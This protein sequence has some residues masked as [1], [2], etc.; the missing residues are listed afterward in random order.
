MIKTI[1]PSEM[2]RVEACVMAE[3]GVSGAAL[4]ERAAARVA[5]QA[6]AML[7]GRAGY[8][9]CL[10]GTGNNGGDGLA[11]MRI[12]AA[13]DD[14]FTGECLLLEGKLSPDAQVQ[15]ERLEKEQPRIAVK[16]ISDE[17]PPIRNAALIIDALFGTGLSRP[18]EGAA[19]A[20][21]ARVREA[22]AAGAAVLAVDIPSGLNGETGA[23]LGD[24]VK[25]DATVVF[26][27]PKLGLYVGDGLDYTGEI[28]VA[29]I[30]LPAELD[31]ADGLSVLEK[32]DLA[33]LLPPRKRISHK[34][35]YG[36]VLLWVGSRGMAG[37]AAVAALAALRTGAGLV[38][39][40]CPDS[41]VDIV[42]MLC[43]CAMCAPLDMNDVDAAWQT[44]SAALNTA[45]AAGAGCGLG[46]TSAV[47]ELLERF[48]NELSNNGKPAVLDADALNLLA[49][50]EKG[51][52][53]KLRD[54]VTLTPHPAEAARLIG[55]KTEDITR[56]CIHAARLIAGEYGASIVLKGASSVLA[57]HD[58]MA[59][60]P[61]GSPGM[62]KGGSGDALTGVL[63]ALFAGC[64]AGAYQMTD[65]QTLQAACALHGLAGEAAARRYGERGALATDLCEMLGSIDFGDAVPHL[66]E[67]EKGAPC[68]ISETSSPL[69]SIV[70][71][72]VDR[73]LGS[74]HPE[75]KEIRYELNY[76]YVQEIFAADND[77]QDAY[78][79]GVDTPVE[80]FEGEV[81]AVIRRLNDAEDKWVV[82]AKGTRLSRDEVRRA[83]Y[84]IERFF[85]TEIECL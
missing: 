13:G 2:R 8:T 61:F 74:T 60:S 65:I 28:I 85:E 20:L 77:W 46:K 59:V 31:D 22:R 19:L 11:A 18:L 73:K 64:A 51:K 41:I 82:A 63:A 57:A 67:N 79:Y 9:L 37:A 66:P 56:D 50:M 58:G 81:V 23:V 78:I 34:G 12:L 53:P 35:S 38:T 55:A 71:V 6:S 54:N 16:R 52:R 30:G 68:S 27:R 25:A 76:G 32:R 45:D 72:T 75:H 84:F 1:T 21:C 40:A 36:R 14:A 43:P 3:T 69:G 80:F 4:M 62:A 47:S 15:L 49:S 24:A 5:R 33:A 44:L 26:H 17:V 70:T 39:V 42:Q 83:T 29:P 7:A 10:C 48:V